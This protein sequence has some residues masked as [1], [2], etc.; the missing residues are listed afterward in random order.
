[1]H[2]R[3]YELQKLAENGGNDMLELVIGIVLGY[4]FKDFIKATIKIVK[5]VL[6]KEIAQYE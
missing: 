5:E 6:K 4:V 1:M 3:R 2:Y